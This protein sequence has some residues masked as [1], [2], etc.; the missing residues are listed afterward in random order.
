MRSSAFLKRSAKP[1]SPE[2]LRAT[3]C[4]AFP[5]RRSVRYVVA[6]ARSSR[7][8]THGMISIPSVVSN[9]TPHGDTCDELA[10]REIA[11]T[12]FD[13]SMGSIRVHYILDV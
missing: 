1:I 10:E 6:P 11:R 3:D 9:R 7:P 8:G 4:G 5:K 2:W 13:G 12:Q